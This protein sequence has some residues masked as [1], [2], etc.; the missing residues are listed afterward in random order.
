[1]DTCCCGRYGTE[2]LKAVKTL[3]NGRG[4]LSLGIRYLSNKLSDKALRLV[5]NPHKRYNHSSKI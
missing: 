5:K 4:S 1:M 2:N 3:L